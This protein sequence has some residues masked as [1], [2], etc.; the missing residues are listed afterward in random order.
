MLFLRAGLQGHVAMALPCKAT[1]LRF[2]CAT[3]G[4]S[5]APGPRRMAYH[6]THPFKAGCLHNEG[7]LSAVSIRIRRG[8]YLPR[9]CDLNPTPCPACRL[10]PSPRDRTT[11]FIVYG[12]A[13]AACL[14]TGRGCRKEGFR[15]IKPSWKIYF[16]LG[17]CSSQR[18]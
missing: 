12:Q 8:Q 10:G 15:R 16:W 18:D 1:F 14:S 9:S 13:T 3:G 4:A 11:P 2:P 7:A 5:H 17:F 6:C